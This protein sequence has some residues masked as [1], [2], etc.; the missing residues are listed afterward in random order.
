MDPQ[1]DWHL[2][3]MGEKVAREATGGQARASVKEK[4]EH[5]TLKAQGWLNGLTVDGVNDHAYAQDS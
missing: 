5:S 2:G 4:T 1:E 3:R